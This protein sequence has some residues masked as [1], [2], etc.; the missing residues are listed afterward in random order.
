MKKLKLFALTLLLCV[1]AGCTCPQKH[2]EGMS[3]SKEEDNKKIILDFYDKAINQKDFEAAKV[4]F[5]NRYV[6]HNPAAADGP[7]GLKGFIE[8]MK[9]NQPQAKAEFLRV[10][11]DGDF[12]YTHVRFTP[13]PGEK[14]GAVMDVF[15]LEDGK[16]VEHWDVIQQVPDNPANTNSMFP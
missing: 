10:L 5:G 4:H 11:A 8:W 1:A 9:V 7:E 2:G 13:G 14:Q 3:S 16:V 12:V 6:Q 15:K